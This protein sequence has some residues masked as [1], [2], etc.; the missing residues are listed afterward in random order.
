M[1]VADYLVAIVIVASERL[2]HRK[3]PERSFEGSLDVMRLQQTLL[4]APSIF[5]GGS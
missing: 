3:S 4:N 5:S 2:W 1:L